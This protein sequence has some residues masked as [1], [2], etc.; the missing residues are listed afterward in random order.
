VIGYSTI[1]SKPVFLPH[2]LAQYFIG[3]SSSKVSVK[4]PAQF[5]RVVLSVAATSFGASRVHQ[6]YV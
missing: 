4:Q 5:H 2:R 6:T 1:L 3:S